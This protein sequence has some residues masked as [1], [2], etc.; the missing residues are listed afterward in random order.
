MLFKTIED[1]AT[2]SGLRIQS[3]FGQVGN[4]IS[5]MFSTKAMDFSGFSTS[6]ESDIAA[7]NNYIAALRSGQTQEE[8]FKATMVE[9]SS[10][11][12]AYANSVNTASVST[13][14]FVRYAAMNKVSLEAQNKTLGN[15]KMLLNEYNSGMANCKLNQADFISAVGQSNSALGKYLTG[16]NGGKASM[17]GY[18]TSLVGAKVASFALQAAT[19]AL[20]AALT[21]GISALVSWGISA[22]TELA[23]AVHT[24]AEEI[25]EAAEEIRSSYETATSE[26]NGNI[27][28]LS[29]LE[30]EFNKLSKGVSD[31]GENVYLT[32]SEYQRYQEIVSQII[33]ISPTLCAGY[34]AEG[35]AIAN[36]NGLIEESIRLL[37]E[38]Q[39]LELLEYTTDDALTT[40]GMAYVQD[41]K[42]FMKDNPLPYGNA[43][44]D[45]MQAFADAAEQYDIRGGQFVDNYDLFK[46]FKFDNHDWND[47]VGGMN[48]HVDAVN[49]AQKHFDQIVKDI[50]NGGEKVRQVFTE[51]EVDILAK[52]ANSYDE[53]IAAYNSRMDEYS[54]ALGSQLQLVASTVEGYDELSAAQKNVIS[55]FIN[56]DQFKLTDKTTEDDIVNMKYKIQDFVKT[57]QDGNVGNLINEL[58]SLDKSN[59]T[60]YTAKVDELIGKIADATGMDKESLTKDLG[61]GDVKA[62]DAKIKAYND[63]TEKILNCTDAQE[64]NKLIAEQNALGKEIEAVTNLITQYDGL[65][66]AYDR[67]QAAQSSENEGTKYDTIAEGLEG[68]KDLYNK[69]LVG[70]D[71]FKTAVQLM[72]NQDLTNA[73]IE[74]LMNAYEVSFPK[75]QRYFKEGQSGCQ[76]FLNDISKLN[77]EWAHMNE[78]GSW[79]ID[80][81]DE[82]V[83]EKLGIS[84]GAVQ[85]IMKKLKDFGFDI[86]LSSCYESLADLKSATEAANDKLK[87]LG[88]TEIDF[89]VN[90]TNV[91]DLIGQIDSASKILDTFRKEDGTVDL[92]V[93]GA[94]EAK[95]ILAALIYQKQQVSEP[96][97]IELNFNA[98]TAKT[99]IESAALLVNDFRTKYRELEVKIATGEDTSALQTEIQ[100]IINKID[101][102]PDEI[103]T[104]L[105]L[106]SESFTTAVETL[107]KDTV[108]VKAGITLDAAALATFNATL[109]NISPEM[110][111]KAGL[112]DTLIK[113]YV[114][115]EKSATVK[116]KVDDSAVKK[117]NPPNLNR[118]VYYT[119][120][121]K[122]DVGA[123]GT[124]F[125]QGNW[126]A[127]KSGIAL[128]GELGQE[129]VVRNGKF[130]TIG[131]EGAEFFNY[132]KDDIIFNAEQ[133]K[134]IFEKGKI[135]S[136]NRRG[137]ALV[138]GTAFATG[139][140]RFYTAGTPKTTKYVS[141]ADSSTSPNPSTAPKTTTEKSNEETEF[142]R[143]YKY[144]QHLLAMDRESVQDY[145]DWLVVAYKEAY[146]AGQMELDDFYKY[147]EEVYDKSKALFDDLIG[148][149]EHQI[150]LWENQGGNEQNI[151]NEYKAMQQAVHEQAEYY[152][153]LG[154]SEENDKIQELQKQWWDYEN[155]IRDVNAKIYEDIVK[156]SEN[157][158]SLNEN[159][160]NNAA[161]EGDYE[162]VKEYSGNIINEYKAMQQA[163]HEQAEYYRSLGYSDTSDEVSELS[164]LWW[165]YQEAIVE[166]GSSGFQILVDNAHEAL[167]E[168]QNVYDTLKSAAQEYG[169]SGFISPDTLQDILSMGV[170]YL[171]MLKNQNGQLEI[172]ER[173]INRVIKAKTEQL[174]VETA[175]NYVEQLRT[176]LTN[177]DV[178]ALNNL[179]DA[180]DA[181]TKSTWDLV[182][183]QL[184]TLDLT[185]SQFNTAVQRINTIRSLT[186]TAISGVGQTTN[187]I[188]DGLSQTSEALQQIL[189]YTIEVIKQE[190]ENK[191]ENLEEQV[192]RYNEIVDLQ[193]ESLATTKKQS[194]YDD[195]VADKLKEISKLQNQINQLSLDDSR[196]AQAE[197]KSLEEELANLQNDLSDYQADY[198]YDA[199]V[200]SLD[201][202]AEAY[203][204]EK[205]E[206]IE[207]LRDSISSYQKLYDLAIQRIEDEGSSLKNTLIAWN[208]EYGSSLTSEITT[209]WNN[210]KKALKE[211]EY[212][213]EKAVK[214]TNTAIESSEKGDNRT[215]S[216]SSY[217]TSYY[218]N[219]TANSIV[220]QM[221]ANSSAWGSTDDADKRSQLAEANQKLGKRL[222]AIG[223]N[224][225]YNSGDGTWYIG[226][227]GGT[228]LYDEYPKYHAGGI[229]G[230]GSLKDKEMMAVLEEGEIV[231]DESKKKAVQQYLELGTVFGDLSKKFVAAFG[232]AV[233]NSAANKYNEI[234]NKDIAQTLSQMNS[235]NSTNCHIDKIE[236]TA[237]IQVTEKL[238]KAEIKKHAQTIGEVSAE[239]IKEGFTKRGIK[240][241]T[242]L[243]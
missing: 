137:R 109:L 18:I 19:M 202:M 75:M 67:W 5:A 126:G 43:K 236:V 37:K 222:V 224:A 95:T 45:F 99:E 36:K 143:Q 100:G 39:R 114:P 76:N 165:E 55:S 181:A 212:E 66:A 104:K 94:Q 60:E 17:K 123:R 192:D 96:A 227:V 71:D 201:K 217:S 199:T 200:E 89:D 77:S 127:S 14:G 53:N 93:E 131:D 90:S 15:V 170:E 49:F 188:A 183:A 6:I 132:Q 113:D 174:G 46:S 233:S 52:L 159:W 241:T 184:A 235:D 32:A 203:E 162:K 231:L 72:S 166:A 23:D 172:N 182:Y 161:A 64:K 29:G 134:Q 133:T 26:I 112:D 180:T 78:D 223:V 11:A 239:Y 125:A 238:D 12:Q 175:L 59:I 169:D 35:Q 115:D 186:D 144:H 220:A 82:E 119:V 70:T 28:T 160:L 163:V 47:Y 242:K 216:D 1:E 3:I 33:G 84:V 195:T 40:S 105:G 108:D 221:K 232:G 4:Q 80:F 153:S 129:L 205:N 111:V 122:G 196:E 148:D 141:P 191:I 57:I 20:N 21:M 124:A 88:K 171:A 213:Y 13:N 164:N 86:D 208:E 225:V 209:A 63:L 50:R 56:S 156:N 54:K 136:G 58:F 68:M 117:Y 215:V 206:E 130:F 149:S 155:E 193:K 24:S 145:L 87:E 121:Q 101:E 118:T 146:N 176:A 38:K 237:P 218:T 168:I 74:Q 92:S 211:Y 138:E 228:K 154:L 179:L 9:A 147:E 98:E 31:Y 27:T 177:N 120:K 106:D 103:K 2:L 48:D 243:F 185:D 85:A 102:V 214:A 25:Q 189:D 10:A 219:T 152:R 16:L 234:M 91:D 110:L 226:S 44:Y 187:S 79:E 34:N 97:I 83:A 116:Y 142:E 8:A 107:T 240:P 157:T 135:S 7:I 65:T 73:T 62:L 128:G 22:F 139:S 30:S 69:G 51:E 204:E 167:D 230:A 61:F 41:I 190:T 158:I 151:I 140:G 150:E 207:I 173:T 178:T 197:K 198:A 210:A 81:N 229:V 194:D 42:D